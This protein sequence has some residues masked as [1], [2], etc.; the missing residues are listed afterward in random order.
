MTELK[1]N[2][3]E[4]LRPPDYS[5]AGNASVFSRLYRNDLIYTDALGWLWWNGRRWERDEHRAVSWAIAL[6]ERMLAEARELSVG[7][8]GQSRG[9]SGAIKWAPRGNHAKGCC[10]FQNGRE[11]YCDFRI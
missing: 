4:S 6:S 1:L 3:S 2:K 11:A 8:H 5:D 9:P 10:R 7:T